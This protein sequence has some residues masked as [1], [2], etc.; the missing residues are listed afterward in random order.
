MLGYVL[1]L[2]YG[3]P[4]GG[5]IIATFFAMFYAVIMY[6]QGDKLVLATTGAKEATK[7]EYPHLFHT[8]EGLALAAGIPK[9]KCYVIDDTALNAFATGTKPEKASITV[10]TGLLKKLNRQ[11]L[12]GVVAHEMSHI[13]NYDIR[14]MLLTAVLV[15]ITILL[16]DFI[17]KS[18]LWG[19]GGRERNNQMVLI[20]IVVGLVLAI[21]APLIGELIKLAVSR[22]REFLADADGALLTRYPEGLASALEKISKDPDPLVD[23]ANKATAHLFISTPFRKKK[24]IVT[25]LF[26]TH[27]PISERIDKLRAM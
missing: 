1:G 21:L 7:K 22:R 15:G 16:S 23:K 24:G 9:P 14:V 26:A 12:E 5:F 13:K 3:L 8:V 10:T 25:G 11:E 2:I 17:L 27:P 20:L 19:R 6:S 4:Y 18:F